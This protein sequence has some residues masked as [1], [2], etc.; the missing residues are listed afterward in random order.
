V[1][2]FCNDVRNLE[3]SSWTFVTVEGIEPT[4]NAAARALRPA[5]LWR[6]ECFGADSAAGNSFV[7]K[8]LTASATGRPHTRHLLTYLTHAVCTYRDGKPAPSLLPA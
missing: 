7:A 6:K 3:P 2:A 1:R 5:V 8:L 4:N